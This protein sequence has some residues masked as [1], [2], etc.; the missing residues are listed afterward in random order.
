MDVIDQVMLRLLREWADDGVQTSDVFKMCSLRLFFVAAFGREN[1][2][3]YLEKF[4]EEFK[5]F[6]KGLF[7]LLPYRIPGTQFAKSMEARDRLVVTIEE[8]ITQFKKENSPESER[9][10][11]T[12]MGRAC[13]G[14]DEDGNPMPMDY[15]KH[16]ILNMVFA[17]HGTYSYRR[18]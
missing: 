1:D 11:T 14:L 18:R 8:M 3:G 16:S 13:Y 4:Y 15:L 2:A 7:H 10:K 9:G 17:G 6:K 5:I 12:M